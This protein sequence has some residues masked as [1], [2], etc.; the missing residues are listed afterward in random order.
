MKALCVVAHPDDCV[1]FAYSYIYNHPEHDWTIG[2]L[3][4]TAADP[5]G[6]ELA[7]FWQRRRINT[8][9]LGFED[10]WHD[11]ELKQFTRWT[12]ERAERACWALA[13]DFD[14]VLTHDESGDYGHI[15]HVLVHN[16]V[17]W[18]PHL[19]TFAP[20]GQ[21]TTYTVPDSAYSLDELPLHAN[22]IA[23]FHVMQHQN[24]YKEPV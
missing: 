18:H 16:S 12:E 5:R 8:V 6:A 22:I 14:L 24:S 21:G 17:Q 15:H 9:F 20:P 3:T 13:K 2:Y 1:I 11:N 7:A 23:G 19:V 10:H 4:Y